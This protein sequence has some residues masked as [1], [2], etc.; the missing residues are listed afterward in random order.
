MLAYKMTTSIKLVQLSFNQLYAMSTLLESTCDIQHPI[1][2][3]VNQKMCVG[4]IT[5]VFHRFVHLQYCF[6]F[7]QC[8][9][10]AFLITI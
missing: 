1:L 5:R 4:W 9:W 6:N 3:L 2:R 7:L 8:L 10:N